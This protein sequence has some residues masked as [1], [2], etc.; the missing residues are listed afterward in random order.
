MTG[1]GQ[2]VCAGRTPTTAAECAGGRGLMLLYRALFG[3]MV[4]VSAD[5][6]GS[7]AQAGGEGGCGE[8]AQLGDGLS[9]PVPGARLQDVAGVGPVSG[10]GDAV[11]GDKHN[12]IVT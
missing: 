11:C 5:R 2:D 6:G 8:R 3:E 12:T 4:E 7:Q 9:Y 1:L 10:G